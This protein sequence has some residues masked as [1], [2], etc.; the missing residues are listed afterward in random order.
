[1]ENEQNK[2]KNIGTGGAGASEQPKKKKMSVVFHRQNSQHNS[3]KT[4]PAGTKKQG[5]NVKPIGKAADKP[6]AQGGKDAGAARPAGSKK[7][8]QDQ[9]QKAGTQGAAKTAGSKD[10]NAS[11]NTAQ[12]A[13]SAKNAAAQNASGDAKP[14]AKPVTDTRQ[15]AKAAADVKAA[16][17][18]QSEKAVSQDAAKD[19]KVL[20]KQ[21]KNAP[22]AAAAE[23]S[24]QKASEKPAE[25]K[26]DA[27]NDQSAA[28]QAE[29]SAPKAAPAAQDKPAA[30]VQPEPEAPRFVDMSLVR[31]ADRAASRAAAN[32]AAGS[33][34]R[35]G[36][37]GGGSR[38]GQGSRDGRQGGGFRQG[39]GQGGQGGRDGRQGGGPRQGQGQ[40]GQGGRDGRQGGGFRQG[41]PGSAGQKSAQGGKFG[42]QGSGR[43]AAVGF[44]DVSMSSKPSSKNSKSSSHNRYD[45]KK[46][47][48]DD[49]RHPGVK[50]SNKDLLRPA[51]PAV[52]QPETPQIK[53]IVLPESLTIRELADKMK[54]QPS[55]IVKKLFMAGKAVTV[56]QEIDYETAAEI[57]LE[58]DVLTEKEVKVNV[59]EELLK[60]NTIDPPES[61]KPRPPVVCVMGHVDHG[62]TSLLD[63]IRKTN[64]TTG[65]AGGITQAIGASVVDINGRK[66]TFLDTPGHEA[67]TAMRMRGAQSTDIA[68]LVVAADDG[69][70]PQ[71]IEAINHAKAAGVE[72]MVAINKIDKPGANIDKVK[73]ELTEYQ[74]VSEEWG[75]KNIFVPV[76]AKTG[77]GIDDLLES[78]LLVAEMLELK[79]NPD[80]KARGLVIE[81]RLDKGKGPVASILVQKGTLHVGDFVAS[82][83]C[84]GKIRAM[85]DDKGRRVREVGPGFPAEIQG[86]TDIPIG[87]EILISTDTEKSAKSYSEAFIVE[88]KKTL[89]NDTKSRMSLEDLYSQI[90]AGKLKEFNIVLKADVQ[91]SVE[92][93]RQSLEKL[94]NDEVVVKIIHGG[95][96]A[97]NES[98]VTLA[99]VSNAII[100]GFNVRLDPV[101]K[102]LSEEEKVDVRLYKVI[103]Q[104]LEDIEAALKGML[105]PVFEERVVGH[106]VVRQTFKASGVGVIAGS[107]VTDGKITRNSKCRLSRSGEQLFDGAIASLK[108]FKDDVKEVS[109]GYEFG[110]V[111]D[112]FNDLREDDVIEAYEMVEVSRA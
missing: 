91:G 75:G 80:R 79:A 13:A 101:A 65:E 110:L 29:A 78:I 51:K 70:M 35:D 93:M 32:R 61:L 105:E 99:S 72:I 30:P 44:A 8:L 64:V 48:G 100:I 54:L 52:K 69:V 106:A 33:R 36:R 107:Y 21:Q 14:A 88:G 83:P 11:R 102:N 49:L 2:E 103:Y 74:I 22:Q 41:A 19:V 109:S 31:A 60:D 66:I 94:S 42:G 71:T 50:V 1:M 112:G 45:S 24:G 12:A 89:I 87:G 17:V 46:N 6:A 57:A 55:V 7:P 77:E 3:L 26:A 56:N 37:Q 39:Q 97:I 76:S 23:S 90:K 58:Y 73:Q 81:A 85:I 47:Y 18:R 68:V 108:R 67:F 20:E 10:G 111:L 25:V 9:G 5:Q 59:I 27:K 34:N 86:L 62:K 28:K 63:A 95:V 16:P 53:E 38:H 84:Y 104:A 43:G 82:G 4:R 15:A 40:G 92:A 96:G 98:D